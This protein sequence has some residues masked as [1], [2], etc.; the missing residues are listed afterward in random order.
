MLGGEDN[1]GHLLE[2]EVS[3]QL[4]HWLSS[5]GG[6]EGEMVTQDT[7]TAEE[8]GKSSLEAPEEVCEQR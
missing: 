2:P 3:S 4:N 5:P 7:E 6:G 8:R 1:M